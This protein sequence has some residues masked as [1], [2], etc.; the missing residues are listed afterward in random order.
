MYSNNLSGFNHSNY[1]TVLHYGDYEKCIR[2]YQRLNL[3]NTDSFIKISLPIETKDIG[4][5]IKVKSSIY[6]SGGIG[7]ILFYS[8]DN[9]LSS[10]NVG[11]YQRFFENILIAEIPNTSEITVEINIPRENNETILYIASLEVNIQ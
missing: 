2:I 1:V 8:N 4:K 5:E 9:I 10:V 6:R 11:S 7:R 3:L